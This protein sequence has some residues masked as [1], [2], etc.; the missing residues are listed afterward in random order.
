V[1][2]KNEH[3]TAIATDD[4]GNTS[5]FSRG[6]GRNYVVI[7]PARSQ[8]WVSGEMETIRWESSDAGHVRIEFSADS[9][10]TYR[11]IT[12]DT[13]GQARAYPWKIAKAVSTH[14][15]SRG[16]FLYA[17]I[18]GGG[19]RYPLSDIVQTTTAP[20]LQEIPSEFILLQ[21]F[22]NPFTTIRY[23]LPV[24]SHVTLSVFNNLGQ[25]VAILQNGEQEAGYHEVKF[26]GN[27]LSS[28][29]YFYRIEAGSYVETKK[30]LLVR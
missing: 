11:E 10:K 21:N 8:L 26:D 23:G 4:S 19:W 15:S 20:L 18:S 30:L 7:A 5:E 27:N 17:G 28:G 14:W 29:V 6:V 13:S 22:P 2:S 25:Q 9:G 24:R 1:V 16:G 3:L 12:P